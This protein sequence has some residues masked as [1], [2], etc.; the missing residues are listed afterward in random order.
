MP[1]ADAARVVFRW[2]ARYAWPP[3]SIYVDPLRT[4]LSRLVRI[5]PAEI[6]QPYRG[7][8]MLEATVDGRRHDIAVDYGD[9]PELQT[10]AV[11]RS[12]LYF[13]MQF[14]HEGYGRRHRRP[15]R[16][17]SGE[18]ERLPLPGPVARAP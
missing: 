7:V 9:D 1:A 3:A 10:E 16:V 14:L 8:V 12:S 11:D 15:R 4:G 13:K 2:P 18:S 5:E 6:P 17:R